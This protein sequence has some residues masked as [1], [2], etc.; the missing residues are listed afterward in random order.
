MP[1]LE[2]ADDGMLHVPGE[3]LP[4]ARPHAQ[5]ELE[6]VGNVALLRPARSSEREPYPVTPAARVKAFE[7][8]LESP[9]P[10][11]PDL[12]ADCLRRENLYH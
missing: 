9:R 3:M 12:P 8:W 7:H 1:I 2:V 6:H 4:G 11:S 5:F 10:E